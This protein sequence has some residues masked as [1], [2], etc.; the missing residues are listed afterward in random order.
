MAYDCEEFALGPTAAEMLRLTDRG[1]GIPDDWTYTPFAAAYVRGDG[2]R[3]GDGPASATWTWEALSQEQLGY[4]FDLLGGAHSVVVYLRTRVDYGY[5]PDFETFTA[6]M[7]RPI[8]DGAEGQP[9][10][11]S[12]EAWERV[13]IQFRLLSISL[14]YWYPGY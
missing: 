10:R 4:F 2:A 5:E 7:Y 8:L 6:I 3:Y 9:A 12:H 14:E 13:M 11:L 1:I